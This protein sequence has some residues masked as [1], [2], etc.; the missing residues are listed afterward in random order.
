GTTNLGLPL[1]LAARCDLDAFGARFSW[2]SRGSASVAGLA[3]AQCGGKPE[4]APDHVW[5]FWWKAADPKG[6]AAGTPVFR[7]P[8]RGPR[9]PPL[10]P[11]PPPPLRPTPPTPL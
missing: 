1:L 7:R 11:H 3:P 8:A 5:L 4:P 9:P 2:L 10:P 6:G